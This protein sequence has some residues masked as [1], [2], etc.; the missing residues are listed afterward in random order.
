MTKGSNRALIRVCLHCRESTSGCMYLFR[1][2]FSSFLG[3]CPGVGLQDHMVGYSIL[4]Y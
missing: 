4:G 1:L 3:M 2:E